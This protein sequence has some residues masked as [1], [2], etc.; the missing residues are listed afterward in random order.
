MAS[1]FAKKR[2]LAVANRPLCPPPVFATKNSHKLCIEALVEATLYH[3]YGIVMYSTNDFIS[4]F[5]L[6]GK[7]MGNPILNPY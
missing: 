7:Y 2:F 6:L 4:V 1:L 5:V 3:R